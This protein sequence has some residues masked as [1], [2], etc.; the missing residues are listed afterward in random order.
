MRMR[1]MFLL[2]IALGSMVGAMA[3]IMFA[4]QEG[5]ALQAARRVEQDMQLMAAAMRV[6][7]TLNV[8]R[9]LVSPLLEIPTAARSEQ[10]AV[11]QRQVALADSTMVEVDRLASAPADRTPLQ[12]FQQAVRLIRTEALAAIVEPATA[13]N[14]TLVGTYAARMIVLQ[15]GF[16]GY[17]GSLRRRVSAGSSTVGISARLATLAWDMRDQAGRGYS[18]LIRAVALQRAMQ[19]ELAEVVAIYKGRIEQIWSAVLDTVAEAGDPGLDSTLATAKTG[20]WDHGGDSY[21]TLVAPNR[22][23]V[24]AVDLDALRRD[25]VPVLNALLPLRD[26]AVKRALQLSH[27]E[28]IGVQQRFVL[29]LGLVVLACGA[30]IVSTIWFDRRVVRPTGQITTTILALADGDSQVAVPLRDRTDELGHM[31][32]AIERLRHNANA[33]ATAE[34]L[35]VADQER[36]ATRGASIEA[37]CRAFDASSSRLLGGLSTASTGMR[38]TASGMAEAARDTQGRAGTVAAAAEDASVTVQTVAAAAEE[39]SATISEISRQVAQSAQVTER[40]VSAAHETDTV[41]RALADG[42]HKIGE[43]VSLINNI[44]SQTNLL[45][46]NATIEAARAGDAGKGFAVVASEVKLLAGQTTRATE[47]IGAQV[48]QIQAATQEA[49]RS[50]KGITR[51]VGE[52]SSIATSIAAAVEQQGAATGEIARNVQQAAHSTSEVTV[53][54]AGVSRTASETGT[55]ADDVLAAA[56][57]LTDQSEEMARE[58]TA[59]VVKV[60]AA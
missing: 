55:A 6:P 53:N 28:V 18:A 13:R 35:R 27:E 58:V 52:I 60:R 43:V 31:A 33:A 39:L 30:A 49:V 21:A 26:A 15:E 9:S 29:A 56:R 14:K 40:A 50:I 24:L 2:S 22:G 47:E 36:A 59:F 38:A 11:I 57:A 51:T 32:Q 1:Q 7:E 48:A 4:V 12:E 20:F 5:N 25:V 8:E 41:V 37:M 45:A 3:T 16:S 23:Q 19:G 34:G 10:V 44:A 54:I 17:I 46:L 42:A